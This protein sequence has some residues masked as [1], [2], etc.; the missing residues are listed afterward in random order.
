MRTALLNA[1]VIKGVAETE[2]VADATDVA[3]DD[4]ARVLAE[5]ADAGLVRLR[6]G[7]MTGWSPTAEGRAELTRLIRAGDQSRPD[8]QVHRDFLPV[9]AD[10]K[11]LCT[12]WQAV[13]PTVTPDLVDRLSDVHGRVLAVIDACAA[14]QPR[15]AA[16]RRRLDTAR[17]RFLGGDADAL[18]GVRSDSYHGVWMELHTG[19]SHHPRPPAHRPGRSLR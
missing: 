2:A 9:N 12:D 18:T 1:V 7:R 3:S 11:Q 14:A 5:L 10:F 19:P 6:T 13:R 17:E 4:A 8:D 15:F 16:Y